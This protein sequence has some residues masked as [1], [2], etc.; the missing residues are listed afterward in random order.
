MKKLIFL[1]FLIIGLY[2]CNLEEL[3]KAEV[4][5]EP[6]FN[7][8]QGLEMYTNSFYDAFPNTTRLFSSLS[9]Y[10][11]SD[12]VIQYLTPGGYSAEES[13]GWNWGTLRNINYFIANC[14]DETLP[15]DVRNNYI[16]IARFFRAYFYFKM[17]KE[18]GDLPWVDHPL[19]VND[20]LLTAGR[21]DRSVIAEKIKEDLDFAINNIQ[22]KKDETCSTITSSVAAA[23]KSR[24]C[25]WEGTYRKYHDEAGL[26]STADQWLQEAVKA[27]QYVMD[28][29]YSIYTGA[30]PKKSY[31][32][33]FTS[34]V[35][36]S[37]EVLYAVTFDRSLGVVNAANHRWTSVTYSIVTG[38]TRSFVKTYLML[39]GTPFTDQP[40]ADT[41]SFV[42]ECRNRD[43]RLSQTI[44]TP[45]YTR[46]SGGQRVEVPTDYGY[47]LTGYQTCK[48]TVD[49]ESLDNINSNENNV[50][51]FRY[52]EVLLNYAEA[53]EELGT[54]TDA[55]WSKTIGVLRARAGITGGLNNKPTRVDTY[56]QR[57]FFP[58]ISDPVLLE[59]RRE[60]GIEL[61]YEGFAWSDVQRWKAGK[62]LTKLWD[63]IYIPKLDV[64]Y[65]MNGDGN[66]DV[67]FTKN[68]NP[69]KIPGVYYS[70]VGEKLGNGATNKMQ[71]EEDGHTLVFMKDQKRVWDDKLYFH[72]IPALDLAKNPNLG[73]N[74][75]W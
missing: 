21:T 72:P 39:D 63:G 2:S 32:E 35:P 51:L 4:S 75:G 20:S 69:D 10:L 23:L 62:L 59:I 38:L 44:I 19:D 46:I 7:S 68:L 47:A 31:R 3:P 71:L 34:K 1:P 24:V 57:R 53:K 9:Y 27:S 61:C 73:Q 67:V 60:R 12:Q 55:D 26:E 33:L 49:D 70:Y 22:V 42:N 5:K 29:G 6:I 25:L 65:D 13:S 50:I 37:S 14:N 66:P 40:G 43:Y 64:P 18:F 17:M 11:A 45:G 15:E 58:K 28:A 74:P 41:M 30:G 52:A 36:V 48:F 56:L 16:G 54:L 8:E